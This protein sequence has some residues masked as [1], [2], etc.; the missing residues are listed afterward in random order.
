MARQAILSRPGPTSLWVVLDEAALR[1]PMGGSAVMRAQLKHL[2]EMSQRSNVTIQVLPFK[3]GGHSAVGGPF[4]VLHFAE[5][6][7]SDVV[8]LEQLASSQY[9]D[10]QD[11][12]DKYL[13]VME[14]LCH[15]AATPEDSVTKL[16]AL[17]SEA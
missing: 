4:S 6:D 16:Q 13:A 14:R 2:I 5:S 12:V 17:L 7:L 9:L 15:Q 8:Y 10:K 3:M 1:R 11:M